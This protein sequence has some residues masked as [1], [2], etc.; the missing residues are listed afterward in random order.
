MTYLALM[1]WLVLAAPSTGVPVSDPI[2]T[3]ANALLQRASKARSSAL[4]AIDLIRLDELHTWLAPQWVEQQLKKAATDT[5]RHP[6][7]QAVAW[8]LVRARALERLDIPAVAEAVNAL[9]LQTGF[10]YRSGPAPH[11][12]APLNPR[13]WKTYPT[14]MGHG[15]I[16]LDSVIRPR[17]ETQGTLAT[18]LI[19]PMGGP[20]ILRLGYDDAVTVWLNGDEVY[21]S[22]E[23]HNHWLDQAAVRVHL[24]KG[25]NRLIVQVSQKSNAWR[26]MLRVTDPRGFVV[27]VTT[28]PKPW[29]PPPTPVSGSFIEGVEH[30]W[31]DLYRIT[32]DE[33]PSPQGIRDLAD[34]A[35]VA[36]L[37]NRDQ[38]L[39]QVTMEMAWSAQPTYTTL[40]TWLRLLDEKRRERVRGTHRPKTKSTDYNGLMTRL[41]EA[42]TT[43]MLDVSVSPGPVWNSS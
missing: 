19:S 36:H 18:Q 24:R 25:P 2:Q 5:Q 16:W 14:A 22:D 11:P 9:G 40:R 10:V 29:G 39:I 33:S 7:A 15:V 43:F 26:F 30:I 41:E 17:K 13:D 31:S 28:E 35:R 1:L 37:P 42:G 6:L 27:P 3:H 12:N 34:Y 20:A 21:T 32:D 8:W 38:T 23:S 4:S